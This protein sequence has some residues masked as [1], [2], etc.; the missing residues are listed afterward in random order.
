MEPEATA[1]AAPTPSRVHKPAF[2]GAT[3]GFL[4]V[5]L[6]FPR[7]GSTG[8]MQ[9]SG[10]MGDIGYAS[11]SASGVPLVA[12]YSSKSDWGNY[13]GGGEIYW[14]PE[15]DHVPLGGGRFLLPGPFLADGLCALLLGLVTGAVVARRLRAE[16]SPPAD[17]K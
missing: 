5:L 4:L 2:I 10:P 13:T 15:E 12:M 9:S 16:P 1:P 6:L 7:E 8:G 11:I 17:V 14:T 3:V